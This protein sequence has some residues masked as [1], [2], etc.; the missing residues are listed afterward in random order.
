MRCRRL[1][2]P[3]ML[4]ATCVTGVSAGVEKPLVSYTEQREPCSVRSATRNAFFGDLHIHT[5]FSYDALPLGINTTPADAY[6]FAKGE[7]LAVPPFDDA[8]DP[9]AQMQLRTP[10]DFAAVTDHA[11]FFGEYEL[12][13]DPTSDVYD[14]ASCQA[15]RGKDQENY[16]SYIQV[17]LS[18]QPERIA[19][20]CGDGGAVCR[21]ASVAPWRATRDMADAAYDRSSACEFTAFVAYEYTGT[22]NANNLHRNVIFRNNIVPEQA[23]SYV[24]APSGAALREQLRDRCVEGLT[25]CDV[26]AI[27]HNS[28]IS[29]GAMFATFARED[30]ATAADSA[31]LRNAMEPLLEV[32]QHKGNSECFNGL[33]GILGAPDEL[34]NEEQ[35][36]ALGEKFDRTGK[37]Y[38]IAFCE[39]GEVGTRGF[40]RFGCISKN[41]F[42]RSVLLT[43]L[44][45]E[46]AI[47]VNSYRLGAI[48]STDTHLSVSGATSEADYKGHLV[49]EATL[50]ERVKPSPWSPQLIDGNPG[51]LA[52]VWAVENSR[53]AL[54][55]AM[56]KREVFGTSGTRI[57]PR[58]FAGW[59]I[60]GDACALRD[61]LVHGYEN[62]VPMGG[63]L[64]GRP[65]DA[66]PRFLVTALQDPS[67][68]PLQKLQLIKGWVD[69]DGRA[70][71]RVID[72]AV[73]EEAPG[74][75]DL[76]TGRY[77]GKGVPSLCAVYEDEDFDGEESTYYYLRAVEVPTLRWNRLQCNAMPAPSRPDACD[78]DAPQTVQ[79]MAWTSPIWYS[80]F[81]Q[82]SN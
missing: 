4:G 71:T 9:Q 78:N 29:A 79:E 53:D 37:R 15:L 40:S 61:H 27:P 26:L 45:D 62:G 59:D 68:A 30:A 21:A 55:D 74:S 51:G 43:G 63:D 1:F 5:G 75:V 77:S 49:T 67:A 42:Y 58:I 33:P 52:G 24:E 8:G 12:C 73:S 76:D 54:F 23:V 28:N 14:L 72:V 20:L 41:D 36:V 25:G 48:G 66:N 46:A 50:G 64:R 39:E 60:A 16:F 34:C 10:L 82:S 47:G 35:V 3:L 7:P 31:E 56:E 38:D 18:E 80:P 65:A 69:G 22:P 11:E 13:T 57:R 81:G 32:F 44:Q 6:R 19:E 17:I 70:H 2:V